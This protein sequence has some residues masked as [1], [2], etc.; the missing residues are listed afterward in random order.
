MDGP[1]IVDATAQTHDPA[2][3]PRRIDEYVG[4]ERV[5]ANL[6]ICISAAQEREE[7]LEHHGSH[8]DIPIAG[9][10]GLGKPL[11]IMVQPIRS[12]REK[13]SDFTPSSV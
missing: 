8:Y 7:P 5:K 2:L 12:T 10:T 6:Q 4:Q 9:G 3:R 11:K 13:H 1:R